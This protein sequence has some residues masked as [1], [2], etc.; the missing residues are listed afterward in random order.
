M[1]V[2]DLQCPNGHVFEGWFEDGASYEV[3]QG[4]GLITCPVCNDGAV[5]RIPAPF[6]IKGAAAGRRS[7][8]DPQTG[9]AILARAMHDYMEKNFD[10]VG[11]EF[12]KE[13]LKMHYG[14]AEQRNIRGVSTAREEEVLRK[15]GVSFF[16]LPSPFSADPEPDS[17][18]DAEE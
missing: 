10:N 1:I 17:S 18:P 14:A 11:A 7:E 12:A 16:K 9:A 8:I 5:Q 3:Q 6:A 4:Q 2:Y 13:A 15:E